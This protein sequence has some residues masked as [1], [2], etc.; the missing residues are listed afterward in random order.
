[1]NYSTKM[2]SGKTDGEKLYAKIGRWLGSPDVRRECGGYPLNDGTD[3][4]W[5]IAMNKRDL[6]PCGFISFEHKP[7]GIVIYHG[8]VDPEHRGRGVFREL[9]RQCLSYADHNHMTATTTQRVDAAV[10]LGILGFVESG[11]RGAWIK[12]DRAAK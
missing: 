12:F 3:Y 9:L 8:Y 5:L 7:H 4:R 11:R 6:S 10:A 2:M 1:M